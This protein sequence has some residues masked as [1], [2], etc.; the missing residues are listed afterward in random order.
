MQ[1]VCET[2]RSKN[3][4]LIFFVVSVIINI[5]YLCVENMKDQIG[6][7]SRNSEFSRAALLFNFLEQSHLFF[8]LF[9]FLFLGFGGGGCGDKEQVTFWD[10]HPVVFGTTVPPRRLA[11]QVLPRQSQTMS[12]VRVTWLESRASHVTISLI[13]FIWNWYLRKESLLILDINR[14]LLRLTV[15]ICWILCSYWNYYLVYMDKN[16]MRSW[17]FIEP[18]INGY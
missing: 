7:G 3:S 5:Q 1:R 8:F 10:C 6:I 12:D 2:T 15:N 18:W 14:R 11:N 9:F 4:N 13:S 17:V 16:L